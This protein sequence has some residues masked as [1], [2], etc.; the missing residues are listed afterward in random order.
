MSHAIQNLYD[1]LLIAGYK[2]WLV[3][4]QPQL[5]PRVFCETLVDERSRPFVFEV[6]FTA[7]MSAVP[8]NAQVQEESDN[9]FQMFLMSLQLPIPLE[10]SAL[11]Q[12]YR[13][14]NVLNTLL[15]M[16]TYLINEDDQSMHLKAAIPFVG[17]PSNA[18]VMEVFDMLT[19]FVAQSAPIIEK[20]CSGAV[21]LEE[22]VAQM[23]A[24]NAP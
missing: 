1:T 22:A 16:G 2:A 5:P 11:T 13:L 20:V 10:Q 4:D 7:D 12:A 23:Q 18:T 3:N 21:G 8:D 17:E 9:T 15:P 24:A 14:F 19:A 6:M